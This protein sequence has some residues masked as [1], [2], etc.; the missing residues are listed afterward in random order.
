MR[1]LTWNVQTGGGDPRRTRL[2]NAELRH[3]AADVVALQ[4]VRHDQLAEL[5][6]GTGLQQ[7]T[8][9][10]DLLGAPPPELARFGG[11]AVA[12][13]LPHRVVDVREHRPSGPDDVHRWT[14]A[15]AVAERLLLVVPTTPWQPDA[16][17][18]RERQAAGVAELAAGSAL[19]VVVAGDLNAG[20]DAPSVRLLTGRHGF[21]DAWAEA[22]SGP[23]WTWSVDNPLA[24]AE[25][26][27]VLGSPGHRAR[28]DHVLAGPGVRVAT[29]R[30]VG[31]RPVAGVWL[32]DHAGLLA[33]LELP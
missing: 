23:G 25:I 2:V 3:L 19:P 14:L 21:R 20:P 33:D 11:T 10:A 12:T 22:G 27:R 31:D 24:A 4:E 1:V 7:T 32:S 26:A 16:V 8:H 15:V 9:Q 5:V 13:R 30:L 6:A 28:I 18:A 29:A 17:A